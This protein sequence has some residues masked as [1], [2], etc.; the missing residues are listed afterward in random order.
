MDKEIPRKQRVRRKAIVYGRWIAAIAVVIGAVMWYTDYSRATVRRSALNVATVTTGTIESTVNATGKVVPGREELILSPIS[1]RVLAVYKASG[2]VVEEGEP[3]LLLDL[4]GVKDSY[5]ALLDEGRMKEEQL[6]QMQATAATALR[7]LE[8]RVKVKE[9]SVERQRVE[10]QNER[11]LDSL[12]SGT[13]DQVRQADYAYRTGMMEL[14]QMRQELATQRQSRAADLRMKQLDMEIFS[15]KLAEMRRTLSDAEVRAT[16]KAVL[17]DIISGELGQNIGAGTKL[18][19][20]SDL[21]HFKVTGT[22]SD[23]HGDKISV[24]SRVILRLGR[25]EIEGQISELS[26]VSR[27]GV[28]TL[29]VRPDNDSDPALRSG[30]RAD[31]YVKTNV[32]NDAVR[33]PNGPYYTSGPGRYE[34]YVMNSDG[35]EIESRPVTLGQANY[36]YVEVVSGLSPGEQVVIGDMT[37]YRKHSRLKI[38]D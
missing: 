10:L 24:G 22:I 5:Q 3:L 31:I 1:S 33:I 7:D 36:E 19:T 14:E 29:T 21:D 34:L 18:A 16:R 9:M 12:G 32:I 4:Q 15:R 37:A 6:T 20:L 28:L 2:D 8:M 13:G 35:T 11:Y 30:L 38:K 27:N 17:T 25:S 23:S 26:P